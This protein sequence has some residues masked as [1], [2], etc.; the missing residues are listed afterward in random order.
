MYEGY[1][2]NRSA[3]VYR[4]PLPRV[5]A[6]LQSTSSQNAVII[7][8]IPQIHRPHI[9]CTTMLRTSPPSSPVHPRKEEYKL[10]A[11]TGKRVLHNLHHGFCVLLVLPLSY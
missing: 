7:P 6:A 3:K 4:T 9:T 2:Y 1:V 10:G 11:V 8:G 5:S